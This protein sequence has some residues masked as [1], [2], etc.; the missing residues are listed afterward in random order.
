[1]HHARTREAMYAIE[2]MRT[3]EHMYYMHDESAYTVVPH[4]DRTA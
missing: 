2:N 4:A 3:H 1:M